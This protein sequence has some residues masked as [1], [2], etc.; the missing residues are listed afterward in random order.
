MLVRLLCVAIIK[1]TRISS[2]LRWDLPLKET[3]QE[4]KLDNINKNTLDTETKLKFFQAV[5]D[6]G[7]SWRRTPG[8]DARTLDE[9]RAYQ[10]ELTM[11]QDAGFR[12]YLSESQSVFSS[13]GD[14]FKAAKGKNT[15]A[16][17][18]DNFTDEKHDESI[19]LLKANGFDISANI[20]HRLIFGK[21][22]GKR[23]FVVTIEPVSNAKSR[24]FKSREDVLGT[25]I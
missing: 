18:D 21:E 8:P 22:M 11:L 9:V 7:H 25:S 23:P 24:L 12:I 2:Y 3:C 20:T 14:Y 15:S 6:T 10:K 13:N 4:F 1:I 16:T 5:D 17:N 19:E